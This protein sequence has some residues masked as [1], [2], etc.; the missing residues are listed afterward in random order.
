MHLTDNE[1]RDRVFSVCLSAHHP[2]HCNVGTNDLEHKAN[3]HKLNTYTFRKAAFKEIVARNR[4]ATVFCLLDAVK[5][6]VTK[7]EKTRRT[8]QSTIIGWDSRVIPNIA[9]CVISEEYAIEQGKVL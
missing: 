8:Q 7:C 1:V 5:P 3:N 2:D 6:K 9:Y 4:I